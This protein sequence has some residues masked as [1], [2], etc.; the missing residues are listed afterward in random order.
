M[1]AAAAYIEWVVQRK[2]PVMLDKIL[3]KGVSLGLAAMVSLTIVAS[4]DAM[5]R[6]QSAQAVGE[7]AAAQAADAAPAC[8][9]L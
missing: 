9:I 2:E 7:L 8:G 5:A 4:I 6:Q 3:H 1:R